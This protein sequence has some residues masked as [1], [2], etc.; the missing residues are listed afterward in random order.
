LAWR[1]HV[2][3]PGLLDAAHRFELQAHDGRHCRFVQRERFSG[4]LVP[5]VRKQLTVETPEA[6]FAMNTALAHRAAAPA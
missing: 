6:F 5:V 4:V 3:V 2:V 1:G